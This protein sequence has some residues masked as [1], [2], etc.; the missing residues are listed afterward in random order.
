MKIS[1]L[2][3]FFLF[4]LS[5]SPRIH[6]N[7]KTVQCVCEHYVYQITALL[8]EIIPTCFELCVSYNW[9]V[10]ASRLSQDTPHSR[11]DNSLASHT[12]IVWT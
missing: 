4:L 6:C 1:V 3:I 2:F 5:S 12:I 7:S 8:M 10:T 11:S 9:Q